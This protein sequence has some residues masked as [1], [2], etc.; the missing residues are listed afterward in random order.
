MRKTT[1]LMFIAVLFTAQ[2]LAGADKLADN[3]SQSQLTEK[4]QYSIASKLYIQQEDK[5]NSYYEYRKFLKYFN[6]S[7][8][9][10]KAQFM[11]GECLFTEAIKAFSQKQIKDLKLKSK[12]DEKGMVLPAEVPF[13]PT[14]DNAIEEYKKVAGYQKSDV[15]DDAL[16]R[17]GECHYNKGNY[18]KAIEAFRA[19]T[20]TYSDSYLKSEAIYSIA[21]CYLIQE[22]WED[23]ATVLIQLSAMYPAYT[24]NPKVQFALG[25]IAYNKNEID[26]AYERF[27]NV[28][29]AEG[30]FYAGRCLDRQ[31]KGFSAIVSY[32]K[33]VIEFPKSNYVERASYSIPESFYSA[34]DYFSSTNSFKKFMDQFPKSPYKPHASY[35]VAC[36][37]FLQ[38]NYNEAIKSF[39]E[40]RKNYP[41]SEVAPVSAYLIAEAL[42]KQGKLSEANVKYG[43]VVTDY[44]KEEVAPYAQYK[45]GWCYYSVAAYPMA[46]GAYEQFNKSFDRHELMPFSLYMTA[47]SFYKQKQYSSSSEYYGMVLDRM[48]ATNL[49]EASLCLLNDS[50]YERRNFDQIIT[51]YQFIAN[52]LKPTDNIWRARTFLYV[53][54]AY[55]KSGLYDDARMVFEMVRRDFKNTPE[56]VQAQSGISYVANSMGKYDLAEKETKKVLESF[57]DADS[58]E[59]NKMVTQSQYE[60]ADNLFNQKKYL[61]ALDLY[62]KFAKENP[63]DPLTPEA[64]Y[65]SGLCYYRLEY[66]SSA[67]KSWEALVEK[68]K[69][70]KKAPEA[71]YQVADT[72]FRAQKYPEAIASFKKLMT[73]YPETKWVKDAQLWIAKSHYNAREYDAAIKE[74][75]KFLEAYP[76]DGQVSEVIEY[77]EEMTK[78]KVEMAAS[79]SATKT[80]K[81]TAAGAEP[82]NPVS[83]SIDTLRGIL[84]KYPNSKIAG[85]IQYK[86]GKKFYE[87]KKFAEAV[88]EF[89]KV[90]MNYP[91]TTS[92]GPAHFFLGES[93]YKLQN[94]EEALGSY[95]RYVRNFPEAEFVIDALFHS[96]TSNYNLKKYAE[97]A[98]SYKDIL[99]KFPESEFASAAMFNMALAYK[100]ANKLEEA[101]NTYLDF[102]KKYPADPNALSSLLE[103]ANIFQKQKRFDLSIETYK[104]YPVKSGDETGVEV[105]YQIAECYNKQDKNE[106]A[107]KELLLLKEMQPFSNAWRLTGLAKLAEIYEGKGNYDEAIKI[108]GDIMK[109]AGKD[110]WI[111]AAKLRVDSIKAQLKEQGK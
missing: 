64:F 50:E 60:I 1:L 36:S 45:I 61:E 22:K 84:V 55:Y 43:G 77:L 53:A 95:F 29:T 83:E 33:V 73:E 69:N 62:E 17:I 38:K 40:T 15:S 42:R 58:K 48:P 8:R 14:F 13:I 103:A 107:E 110:E 108:Y 86:I 56:A 80:A 92:A 35:R 44:L 30:Y 32:R 71:L 39:E 63:E 65:R 97:A 66:Y 10:S 96:A 89:T 74:F 72:Y 76:N 52:T 6:D 7:E 100:K 85:E 9:A 75:N 21:V 28:K 4:G 18:E 20:N 87:E 98:G 46:T 24:N 51:N 16:F 109:N 101:A 34:T 88:D 105:Q 70:D 41:E 26:T 81:S 102:N 49:Y 57:E 47:N 91:E 90:I 12:A 5:K 78:R 37:Y 67:I 11:L 99:K 68:F 94:Y 2:F 19:L 27:K 54:D 106:E 79:P 25:L 104:K 59:T 3:P 93:Y 82:E 23:A 31:G 111:N